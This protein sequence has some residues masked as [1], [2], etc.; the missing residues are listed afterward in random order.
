MSFTVGDLI[1]R[2][3]ADN[4]QFDQAMA[5]SAKQSDVVTNSVTKIDTALKQ[6]TRSTS[7]YIRAM[8]EN[9]INLRQT[10]FAYDRM[11]QSMEEAH[12]EALKMNAALGSGPRGTAGA[13]QAAVLP[14][15]RVNST[16][17]I[18][19]Q[20][21]LGVNP[22]LS[23]L[24]FILGTF[25]IGSVM[26]T[27][28]LAGLAAFAFAW[29][30]V[31]EDSR[32][33]A[34]QLKLTQQAAEDLV[35]SQR[36]EDTFGSDFALKAQQSQLMHEMSRMRAEYARVG[37]LGPGGEL[38][39]SLVGN[40]A[41]ETFEE[42]KR[43]IVEVEG[44]I[45]ALGREIA[46]RAA[47][48]A[49]EEEK[50]AYQLQL[51][52]EQMREMVQ[53]ANRLA[54]KAAPRGSPVVQGQIDRLNLG[55]GASPFGLTGAF[56][57]VTGENRSVMERFGSRAGSGFVDLGMVARLASEGLK[58][59]GTNARAASDNVDLV[60]GGLKEF[61]SG[62]R[63]ALNGLIDMGALGANL[64]GQGIGAVLGALSSALFDHTSV[65]Q[66]NTRAL[67]DLNGQ[68]IPALEE[69]AN[70]MEMGFGIWD[71][72][73]EQLRNSQNLSGSLDLARRRMAAGD[74]SDP[75]TEF[76][77]LKQVLSQNLSG[78]LGKQVGGLTVESV[79]DFLKVLLAQISAGTFDPK[80][81]GQIG[82]PE[83]L[84][85]LGEMESL[86]D[87][88]GEAA[89][90]LGA[91]TSTVRNAPSGYRY[92]FNRYMAET[93]MDRPAGGGGGGVDNSVVVQGDVIVVTDDPDEFGEEMRRQA[94]RGG[95]TSLQLATR[96]T[97]RRTVST[98]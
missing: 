6:A 34:E 88:A 60:A 23:N 89:G 13:A 43:R 84:D 12:T 54:D 29:R 95:T 82:L 30:K 8:Q 96:P 97:A 57:A 37:R 66:E 40:L 14:L 16:L 61:G 71:R 50:A 98:V 46:E 33:A 27:G 32:E 44:Q 65:L 80:T 15:N 35:R 47:E 25:A 62:L 90:E 24:G 85:F 68:Q 79:G 67:R 3:R 31:K 20:Q 59:L 7:P 17:R 74:V 28:V 36:L 39:P 2:L 92:Q 45:A 72:I 42:D 91:L 78:K 21:G 26:M 56:G 70:I 86:G 75:T 4:A 76:G 11:H 53:L 87:A 81:L 69:L 58:P 83:F 52:K 94:R 41:D 5:Q 18:L 63:G 64:A 77:I 49:E 10:E 1:A 19:A 9:T 22:V 48:R 73:A 51:Q 38:M 55:M 93:P